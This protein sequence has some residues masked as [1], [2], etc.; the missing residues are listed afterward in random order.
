MQ[1][2]I[3]PVRNQRIEK[4]RDEVRMRPANGLLWPP[5]GSKGTG[6]EKSNSIANSS[7]S[8]S[9]SHNAVLAGLSPKT[10]ERFKP[11]LRRILLH[12][13]E[14]LQECGEP[15]EHIYF[16]ERGLVSLV[17]NA[18]DGFQIET[19]V[20]GWEGV[21]GV[22]SAA[23]GQ[24]VAHRVV[25]QVPG[26]AYRL[27][28]SVFRDEWRLDALLQE[29]ILRYVHLMLVQTSQGVLCNR[30]HSI[31]ERLC[32]WLLTVRDRVESSELEL[33]HACTAHMLGTRRSGVTLALGT[34]QQSGLIEC[35]RAHITIVDHEQLEASACE[36]YSRLAQSYR[37]YEDFTTTSAK[38]LPDW[39]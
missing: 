4:M 17:I 3:E 33:T 25:V 26:K 5:N 10:W 32:R 27:P 8:S 6:I 35:A 28:V 7:T 22:L 30:I 11:H 23:S 24:P 34:L 21:V 16:I 29:W 18:Q 19:S 31:E 36:C 38:R 2:F 15:A 14:V 39:Q 20:A 1:T 12:Q 9:R 37:A 13:N